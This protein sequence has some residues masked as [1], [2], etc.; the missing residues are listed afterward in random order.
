MQKYKN[1]KEVRRC[2][3]SFIRSSID[4][5]LLSSPFFL[6]DK[7]I[8]KVHLSANRKPV[9]LRIRPMRRQDESGDGMKDYEGVQ[10][11]R[12]TFEGTQRENNRNISYFKVRSDIS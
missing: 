12:C 4:P 5:S 10:Q 8:S 7:V 1:V 9:Q 2:F 6:Q 11:L 3:I